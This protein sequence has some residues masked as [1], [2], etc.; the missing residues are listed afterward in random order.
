MRFIIYKAT[1]FDPEVVSVS[2]SALNYVIAHSSL[3]TAGADASTAVP[4]FL[5]LNAE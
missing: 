2:A 3:C 1:E 4:S 5:M